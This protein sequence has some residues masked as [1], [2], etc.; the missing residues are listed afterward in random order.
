M[1]NILGNILPYVLTETV[2]VRGL[3]CVALS[4]RHRVSI[5]FADLL[6]CGILQMEATGNSIL[7]ATR[8]TIQSE[9][10]ALRNRVTSIAGLLTV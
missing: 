1:K 8:G 3:L 10:M 4:V 5:P 2:S 6:L 9:V 7:F